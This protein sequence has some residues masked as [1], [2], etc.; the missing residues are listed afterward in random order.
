MV[1]KLFSPE[2][3]LRII[4]L[5]REVDARALA[6]VRG[7]KLDLGML[8]ADRAH[9]PETVQPPLVEIPE[10]FESG[11]VC[12]ISDYYCCDIEPVK[13]CACE[14]LLEEEAIMVA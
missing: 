12:R 11:Q 7:A 13:V 10:P 6:L 3:T 14:C 5:F 8:L 1:L 4:E 2:A 9:D